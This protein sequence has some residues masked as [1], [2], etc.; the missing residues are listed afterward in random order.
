M[1][2]HFHTLGIAP[3]TDTVA[4]AK[5]YRDQV[6]ELLTGDQSGDFTVRTS[7][8]QGERLQ[9]IKELTE[10]FI[11]LSHGDKRKAYTETLRKACMLC[12]LCD[13][14]GWIRMNELCKYIP[15]VAC[16]ATGWA[17]ELETKRERIWD[18]K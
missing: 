16:G 14:R 4:T 10:A 18:A 2:T 3:G 6:L 9:R 8:W 1:H 17:F 12:S 11:V 13:G 5:A 7:M 15:C